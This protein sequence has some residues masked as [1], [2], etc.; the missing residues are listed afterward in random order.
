MLPNLDAMM[1]ADDPPDMGQTRE[2][3]R[4]I[5]PFQQQN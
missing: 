1:S 3:W 5:A 2:L 4:S